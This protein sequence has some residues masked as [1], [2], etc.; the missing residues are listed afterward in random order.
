MKKLELTKEMLY[1]H[2]PVWKRKKIYKFLDELT[3]VQQKC[4]DAVVELENQ[5]KID[6][7]KLKKMWWNKLAE[8]KADI[9][10]LDIDEEE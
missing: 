7:E 9:N 1:K 4:N 2:L 5:Q 3:I 10:K 6:L 8:I